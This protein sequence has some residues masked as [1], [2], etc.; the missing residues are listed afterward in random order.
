MEEKPEYIN[1]VVGNGAVL[2]V[3]TE[4]FTRWFYDD[5]PSVTSTDPVTT[6]SIVTTT[7]SATTATEV[8]KSIISVEDILSLSK[9]G[10]S[11]TWSDF[12]KYEHT[13]I[14]DG[15][16]K[17]ELSIKNDSSKLL[18]GGDSLEEKPDYIQLKMNNGTTLDVRKDDLT[19]WYYDDAST[20]TEN[21]TTL[22]QTGYSDIYKVM[23]YLA[24]F[25]TICGALLVVRNRKAN[26]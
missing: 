17:W 8:Q 26:Q 12:E 24:V 2:D 16:Y 13:A 6:T 20:T 23:L 3:R 1:Y 5:S 18:I 15:A 10:E 11:L 4:E 25:M 22:P 9:K 19:P 7:S 14:A 21:E